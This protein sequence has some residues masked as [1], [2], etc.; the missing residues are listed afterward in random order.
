LAGETIIASIAL[1]SGRSQAGG[2]AV[3]PRSAKRARGGGRQAIRSA[4]SANT[5]RMILRIRCAS[6]AVIARKARQRIH[7]VIVVAE[8]SSRALDAGRFAFVR[9]VLAKRA[10]RRIIRPSNTVMARRAKIA[11]WKRRRRAAR[12]INAHIPSIAVA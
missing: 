5:A 3:H 9:V 11:R 8:R 6:R 10:K 7:S 12:T 1:P 2:G 4:E